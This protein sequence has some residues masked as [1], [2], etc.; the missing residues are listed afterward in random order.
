MKQIYVRNK[1]VFP[2]NVLYEKVLS[3]NKHAQSSIS[4]ILKTRMKMNAYKN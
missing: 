3:K 2:L 1:L 4:V